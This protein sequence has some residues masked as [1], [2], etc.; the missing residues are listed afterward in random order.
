MSHCARWFHMV[1]KEG[2]QACGLSKQEF[3]RFQRYVPFATELA[4]ENGLDEDLV[5]QNVP[6]SSIS[7]LIKFKKDTP[8]RKNAEDHIVKALK[9]KRRPTAKTIDAALG[10][11]S[12]VKSLRNPDATKKEVPRK[13]ILV[14][15]G[16][17][18]VKMNEWFLSGLNSGQK[19]QWRDFA[20]RKDIDNEYLA[21]CYITTTLKTL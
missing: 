16:S 7:N 10:I 11:E 21:F 3:S 13:V 4:K 6:M 1:L 2:P 12:N 14:E 19:Q 15:K 17:D 5:F 20:D 9:S 8:N 18:A